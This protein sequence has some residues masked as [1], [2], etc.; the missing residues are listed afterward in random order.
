MCSQ[1]HAEQDLAGRLINAESG[2]RHRTQVFHRRGNA[3]GDILCGG[4]SGIVIHGGIHTHGRHVAAVF[5]RPK[6]QIGQKLQGGL[7]RY[8][9]LAVAGQDG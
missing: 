2:S 8:G 5:G 3:K 7:R 4:S 9:Q 1:A 6:S